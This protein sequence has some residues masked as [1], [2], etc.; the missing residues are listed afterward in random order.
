MTSNA[1]GCN[2]LPGLSGPAAQTPALQCQRL[3]LVF[4]CPSQ[5]LASACGL[6][7]QTAC[8]FKAAFNEE[9]YNPS[10]VYPAAGDVLVSLMLLK[11]G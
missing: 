2:L 6:C 5:A 1:L 11:A 8:P 4:N 10:C 7:S 3:K 9:F